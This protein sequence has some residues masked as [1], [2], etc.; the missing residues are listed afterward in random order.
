MNPPT[1][2][3]IDDDEAI[4]S[5]LK[6]ILTDAGYNVITGRDVTSVYEIEKA[7]PALLLI[8]NWLEGKSGHDICWQLKNDPRTASIPV[9]LISATANLDETAE[10]CRADS[11]ICKPFDVDDLLNMVGKFAPLS[12]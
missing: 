10:R 12:R 6:A 3:I 2:L 7:P 11:F 1:I 4:L 5:L 8:D 9:V